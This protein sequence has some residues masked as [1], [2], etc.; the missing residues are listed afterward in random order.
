MRLLVYIPG[1]IPS[2][3]ILLAPLYELQRRQLVKL[4]VVSEAET[5]KIP[6]LVH[7]D[8]IVFVRNISD[9][10]FELAARARRIN[11]PYIYELDDDFFHI[12]IAD[13]ALMEDIRS[14]QA[15]LAP[16]LR[17][18]RLVRVYNPNMLNSMPN[19]PFELK[20]VSAAFDDPGPEAQ[21]LKIV[22]MTSRS[23]SDEMPAVFIRDLLHILD[24][25]DGAVQAYMYGSAY[26]FPKHP[27]LKIIRGVVG[28][29]SFI[30]TFRLGGWALGLAPASDT[31]FFSRKT[32]NKW[33]E[34]T[35]AGA[36]SVCTRL[37]P[38]LDLPALY[39][40]PGESWFDVLKTGIE[41][42]ALRQAL[43]EESLNLLRA[44]HSLENAVKEWENDIGQHLRR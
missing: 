11:I 33:R 30:K 36:V 18:A 17:G 41:N 9:E 29:S 24:Y 6:S 27:Q 40:N 15:K 20:T 34:Y 2:V 7:V 44:A 42:P 5:R 26:P 21:P 8:G 19:I 14:R 25:Y 4:Q 13:A 23:N 12:E 38:Y 35:A 16:M 3:S 43:R 31:M 10:A 37:P 39:V 32:N 28:Y 1:D 22:Y